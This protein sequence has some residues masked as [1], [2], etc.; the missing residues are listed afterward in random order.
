MAYAEITYGENGL[1]MTVDGVQ[2]NPSGIVG[3]HMSME[4]WDESRVLDGGTRYDRTY[5]EW[6]KELNL[7]ERAFLVLGNDLQPY[8]DRFE[9]NVIGKMVK[10]HCYACGDVKARVE[11]DF[12]ELVAPVIMRDAP[13]VMPKRGRLAAHGILDPRVDS[14]EMPRNLDNEQLPCIEMVQGF[15]KS[16][17]IEAHMPFVPQRGRVTFECRMRY[18]SEGALRKAE[19]V[20]MRREYYAV[21]VSFS[22]SGVGRAITA[23]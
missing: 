11:R 12:D 17:P 4:D 8:Q 22:K 18:S 16:M 7:A 13:H 10:R 23:G 1:R 14:F 3:P 5:H 9:S 19:C 6:P 2:R 20:I 21:N 15:A